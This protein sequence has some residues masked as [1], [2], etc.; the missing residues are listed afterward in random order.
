MPLIAAVDQHAVVG[1]LDVVGAHPLQDVAEQVELLVDL[2]VGGG[3]RI[4]PAD[5]EHGRGAGKAGQEHESPEREVGFARHPCTFREASDHQG[6]GSIDRPSFRNSMYRTGPLSCA[7]ASGE[8]FQQNP[9]RRRL[10]GED[11]LAELH[12]DLR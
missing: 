12:I 8:D 10:A 11:E 2:G 4:R 6:S 1:L 9:S 7:F 5:V 3:R